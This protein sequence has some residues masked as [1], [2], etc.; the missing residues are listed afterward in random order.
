MNKV[1]MVLMFVA[2][3]LCGAAATMTYF[4]TK[5]E[6][7]AEEEIES[8][9]RVFAKLDENAKLEREE[10]DEQDF[11]TKKVESGDITLEHNASDKEMKEYSNQ[12]SNMNYTSF[13]EH[14]KKE[15]EPVGNEPYIIE[16][17]EFNEIGYS[18]ITLY[19]YEDGELADEDDELIDDIDGTV[20][21]E[22]IELLSINETEDC[23]YVRND[24]LQTDFE[25]LLEPSRWADIK[26]K[27]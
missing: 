20:G 7:I 9:K 23:I 15:V 25:I 8:V 5:Y 21:Q 16:P 1:G 2:G 17:G 12:I 26:I 22:A 18:A 14:L 3:A 10:D 4:R 11:G 24:R 6:K 19:L 13:S 27:K